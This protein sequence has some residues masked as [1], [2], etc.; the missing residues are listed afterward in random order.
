MATLKRTSALL[1]IVFICA[2]P[3]FSD[4]VVTF[5]GLVDGTIL[6]NQYPGLTFSNAVILSA[7]ISLNEFEFPPY[8]G[9]NV[10]SDNNGPMSIMFAT[11]ALTFGGYFNYAVP[12]ELQAFDASNNVVA[13]VLSAFSSNDALYGDPGSSPNEFLQ[14]SYGGGISYVTITGDLAG[15]S[16]TLDD[17]TYNGVASPVPEPASFLLISTGIGLLE[18]LRLRRKH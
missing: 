7:G 3:A 1:L 6:T 14:V 8:S 5:E 13:S 9:T 15:S 11:P 12:L 17:A 18:C 2:A 10:A 4:T 16:F